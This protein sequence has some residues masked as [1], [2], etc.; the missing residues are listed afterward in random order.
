MLEPESYDNLG[1]LGEF[2]GHPLLAAVVLGWVLCV[3][4]HAREPLCDR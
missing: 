4:A 3:P 2:L 1:V